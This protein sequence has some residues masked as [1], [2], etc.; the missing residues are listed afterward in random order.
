MEGALAAC[1]PRDRQ[2]IPRRGALRR[3]KC[4]AK[5]LLAAHHGRLG[6]HGAEPAGLTEGRDRT[7]GPTK[8][9]PVGDCSGRVRK[10]C[11]SNDRKPSP[12]RRVTRSNI[13][14]LGPLLDSQE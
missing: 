7:V 13:P 11:T 10:N 4:G 9:R 14:Y 8:P 1:A 6:Y 2:Q 3:G 12:D 5:P